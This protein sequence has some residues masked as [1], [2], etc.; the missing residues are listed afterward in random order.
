MLTAIAVLVVV[1]I[2]ISM[3]IIIPNILISAGKQCLRAKEGKPGQRK[4]DAG[5]IDGRMGGWMKG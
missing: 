5:R 2:I 1:I 3:I 4:E